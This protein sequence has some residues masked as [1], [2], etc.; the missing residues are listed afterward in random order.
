MRNP[1]VLRLR[2]SGHLCKGCSAVAPRQIVDVGKRPEDADAIRTRPLVLIEQPQIAEKLFSDGFVAL[3]PAHRS[4]QTLRARP[5]TLVPPKVMD[6]FARRAWRHPN[7]HPFSWRIEVRMENLVSCYIRRAV[8]YGM[9]SK[10]D[11]LEAQTWWEIKRA[12][13]FASSI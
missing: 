4:A 13:L 9:E 5:I 1:L 2:C 3:Y 10:F 12:S 7:G 8:F 6:I 11:S